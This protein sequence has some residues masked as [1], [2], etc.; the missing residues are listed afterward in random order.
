MFVVVSHF[1]SS[2][3]FTGKAR[4]L[5]LGWSFSLAKSRFIDLAANIRLSLEYLTVK[6][7]S[8]IMIYK[9]LRPWKPL[10]SSSVQ[11]VWS[12]IRTIWKIF[13]WIVEGVRLVRLPET[14]EEENHS[15]SFILSHNIDKL[16]FHFGPMTIEEFLHR[17]S[18]NIAIADDCISRLQV[19][20]LSNVWC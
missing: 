6:N 11:L 16:R 3:I 20:I 5:P 9:W 19:L 15:R 18:F 14:L 8:P 12:T 1:H 13:N 2:K 4:S 17:M 7:Y 10:H